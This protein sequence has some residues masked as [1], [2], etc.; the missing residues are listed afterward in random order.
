MTMPLPSR[1]FDGDAAGLSSTAAFHLCSD[2]CDSDVAAFVAA[3]DAAT[4]F[5]SP[6]WGRAIEDATGHRW[7]VLGVRDDRGILIGIL[8]LHHVRSHLFGNALVSSAF[9]VGGGILAACD[10]SRAALAAG[11]VDLAR[12]LGVG[13]I[14]LRGAAAPA[15]WEQESE[16]HLGFVRPLAADDDAELLAIPRKHR[17]EVRK[18]LAHVLT[19]AL[20]VRTGRD[21][22]DRAAHYAT[23]AT[24]VRNLGTPVFPRRLFDAVLDGFGTNADILTV[25]HNDAA[26]AGVLSL[27]WKGAVMPYWGGGVTAARTLRAN[28]VMYFALMGHAREQG[29][30]HFDFGRSK[31][32]SGPAAY[33]RNW[34]FEAQPLTYAHWS[35]TGQRR[36]TSP[37]SGKYQLMVRTWQKLPLAIANRIG[38][39][40]ARQ[41]G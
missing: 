23:Y 8:P 7:H 38:P 40:I 21:A 26:V 28:E 12:S 37:S 27:Y 2:L 34:G 5:H 22:R 24:S 31:V 13:H 30:S 19:N 32:G 35:A 14:E 9:A 25:S 15:G 3:S 33:K 20:T 41:L 36:D 10:G 11:A 4:P 18:G 16:S 29:M 17:A 6:A 39:L 1:V